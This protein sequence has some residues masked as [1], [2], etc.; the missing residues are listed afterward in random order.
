[1][2][3]LLAPPHPA[4]IREFRPVPSDDSAFDAEI[5]NAAGGCHDS[6]QA[7][8]LACITARL[9]VRYPNCALRPQDDL[10]AFPG[11]PPL[12]YVYRDG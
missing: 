6:G 4:A 9:R 8:L 11:T 3:D 10:A 7:D 5:R 12:I 1:M 2:E